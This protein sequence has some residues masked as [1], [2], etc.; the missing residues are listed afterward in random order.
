MLC[1]ISSGLIVR[2]NISGVVFSPSTTMALNAFVAII[3][4]AFSL[5]QFR[6]KSWH[7]SL[8]LFAWGGLTFGTIGIINILLVDPLAKGGPLFM[9]WVLSLVILFYYRNL[10]FPFQL[11]GFKLAGNLSIG[12][13]IFLFFK[14][15][16]LSGALFIIPTIGEYFS[17]RESH[18]DFYNYTVISILWTIGI[19]FYYLGISLLSSTI[20]DENEEQ[21]T[22]IKNKLMLDTI[23]MKVFE[24]QNE[25]LLGKSETEIEDIFLNK[26]KEIE[27]N[28]YKYKKFKSLIENKKNDSKLL[29]NISGLLEQKT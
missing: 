24:I 7:K 10:F 18:F 25:T 4:V 16:V 12:A 21:L 2:T 22:F 20:K 9:P 6:F 5:S 27:S 15:L 14:V 8:S 3:F 28:Y 23:Q 1:F 13:G 17:L 26:A 19:I 29:S 11:E